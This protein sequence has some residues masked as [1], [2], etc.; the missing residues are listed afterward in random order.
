VLAVP[1]PR[2]II[3]DL[4]GLKYVDSTGFAAL[5]RLLAQDAIVV[6]LAPESVV[7]KAAE[8]MCLPLHHD[9]ETARRAR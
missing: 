1:G 3:L 5:D 4:S 9:V 6:V 7:Y 8:V 2:P